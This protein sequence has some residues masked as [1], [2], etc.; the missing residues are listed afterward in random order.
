MSMSYFGDFNHMH[1][2]VLF[3]YKAVQNA[4]YQMRHELISCYKLLC[5]MLM[6]GYA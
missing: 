2:I 3:E 4:H 5:Y 6:I 1:V